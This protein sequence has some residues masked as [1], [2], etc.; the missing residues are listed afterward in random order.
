MQ[1]VVNH[2]LIELKINSITNSFSFTTN[3]SDKVKGKRIVGIA[4]YHVSTVS[5]SPLNFAN[6]NDNAFKMGYLSLQHKG[7][8]RLYTMPLEMI[9][10]SEKTPALV[11]ALGAA[12][13]AGFATMNGF[14]PLNYLPID[15]EKSKLLFANTSA[16]VLNET[17][18]LSVL[19]VQN[20]PAMEKAKIDFLNS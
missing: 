20:V 15:F 9:K 8:D 3:L 18:I 12:A 11:S 4:A 14:T 6:L 19:W 5:T 7:E 13:Q 10:F 1:R 16:L 2:E 17:L